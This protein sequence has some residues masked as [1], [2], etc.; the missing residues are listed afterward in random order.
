MLGC[1]AATDGRAYLGLMTGEMDLQQMLSEMR[2]SIRD[3]TYCMVS[4]ASPP[5]ELSNSAAAMIAEEEAVT[6]VITTEQADANGLPYDFPAAW[7]TLEVHSSL[8]AVGLTAAV[9]QMLT[10]EGI[11]CNVL[12]GF[13]HDHL[14]VPAGKGHQV[15]ALLESQ[16]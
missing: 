12:A 6:L 3:A 11:P 5:A 2:V 15:K 16:T 4:L 13:Y 10:N 1:P 9:A 14:L 7:L 8:H